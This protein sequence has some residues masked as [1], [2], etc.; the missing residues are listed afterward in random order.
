MMSYSDC[1]EYIKIIVEII[2]WP[3]ND[4]GNVY[5]SVVATIQF[6]RGVHSTILKYTT[7]WLKPNYSY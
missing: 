1:Y 3:D 6:Y 7:M 5:S 4:I 2:P